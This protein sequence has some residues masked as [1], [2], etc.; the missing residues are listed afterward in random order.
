MEAQ[1]VA[2]ELFTQQAKDQLLKELQP[3]L[4][5]ILAT[6][7]AIQARLPARPEPV[8]INNQRNQSCPEAASEKAPA[9]RKA[10]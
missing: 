6:L 7:K 1:V 9:D 10:L 4:S 2:T 8:A 5:E 3:Q